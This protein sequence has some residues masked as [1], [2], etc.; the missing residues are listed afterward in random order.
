MLRLP[1]VA[2]KTFLITIGDRTVGGLIARDPM[3][4]PWQVP[5]ADCARHRGRLRRHDRRGDGDGR[6]HAGRAARRRRLGAPGGRRGDHQPRRRADRALGDVKLSANWM[7]AAGHPGEDARSTTRCAP[8]G[9][10]SARRSASRSPSARTRCRCARSGRR[11][12]SARSVT[13]PVSLIVTAFAPVTDVRRALTPELRADGGDSTRAAAGRPRPR[14]ESPRRLG[15]RAGLRQLGDEP[16]DLDDPG[17]ARAASSPRSRSCNAAGLLLAYHDRSDGGLFVT[18]LEMAFAGGI[19]L[20]VDRRPAWRR[21]PARALFTEELGA[22]VQVRGRRR[23]ARA[24]RP[25]RAT[26]S[27]R[28]SRRLGAPASPAIVVIFRRGG[29]ADLRRARAASCA[30]SGRRRRTRCRR[31]AT[32]R[33]APT[34]SRPAASRADDPGLLA[35]LTFDLADDVA[36]PLRGRGGRARASRSCASR[37]ST[38]R[39]R[40]PPRSP[41]RLRAVDV[42]MTDCSTG[43]RDL[44]GFRGLAA[45]GGF[46]YGDV[47]GAGEGW[48]KSILLQRARARAFARLLRPPRHVRARRLQRLPDARRTSRSSSP[49]PSAWPRFVRNRSEQFEARLSLVEDREER[50]RSSSRHGRLA[51]PDRGRARRGPRRVRQPPAIARRS[52]R[53]GLVAARFVDHRGRV[54]RALPGQ[55]QRLAR[56]HHG[57]HDAPTAASPS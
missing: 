43:A 25:S 55:P 19:G 57:A 28:P 3:V 7:A 53:A 22:V 37:A 38:A 31:C 23:R 56:R 5:V 30:A 11:A 35:H 18:L 42:H 8:S 10:S 40:W 17:A 54:D 16:P 9:A 47:L 1:T 36:A 50:R 34:T 6:A 2:D 33:P 45:C 46:S 51:H 49:A 4:G 29:R 24:R 44:A 26:A 41:R 52:R 48:A 21:D 13:A 39:S 14:Q 15:A 12:A 32:T 27:A 20:D